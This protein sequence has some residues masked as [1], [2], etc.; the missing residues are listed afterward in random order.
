[1][2]AAQPPSSDRLFV[3]EKWEPMMR[4]FI[5]VLHINL[6]LVEADGGIAI[7]P[8]RDGD[9]HRL[10]SQFLLKPEYGLP[11]TRP[12]EF[13]NAFQRRGDYLEARTLFDLHLFAIPI[14]N[15]MGD[16]VG[17]L[18]VG[19]VI[20]N[21]RWEHQRYINLAGQLKIDATDLLDGLSE[22]RVVSFVTMRSILELLGGTI[23]DAVNL[24]L[25]QT[26]LQQRRFQKKILPGNIT[27]EAEEIYRSIH[28]DQILTLAL[29]IALDFTKADSGSIM[30]L[31]PPGDTLVL[32][33]SR[34]LKDPYRK[35]CR[36]NVE[37]GV[38]GVALREKTPLSICGREGPNRIR[39]LLQRDEVKQSIVLPLSYEGRV[40]GVLNLNRTRAGGALRA[41]FDALKD[42]SQLITAAVPRS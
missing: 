21:K 10:G 6:A 16:E 2:S 5:D 33:A 11:L 27:H 42:L 40:I 25:E 36:V 18:I 30:L 9:R 31:E 8:A 35:G 24:S 37:S 34:G 15:P 26:A 19:P 7:G 41:K 32:K 17:R 28:L 13:R 38:A 20:L 29:N 1:M 12:E 23:Q 39:P 22:L 4:R 3:K 14:M